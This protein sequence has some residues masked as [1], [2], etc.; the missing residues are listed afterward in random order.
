VLFGCHIAI[1]RQKRKEHEI[2][3]HILVSDKIHVPLHKNFKRNGDCYLF[4]PKFTSPILKVS[5]ASM[6]GPSAGFLDDNEECVLDSC[7]DGNLQ[8]SFISSLCFVGFLFVVYVPTLYCYMFIINTS[9]INLGTY[10]VKNIIFVCFSLSQ[11]T[12]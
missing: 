10:I 6:N 12:Q 9:N 3:T 1:C 5:V 4:V 11:I 2:I 7:S 8:Q